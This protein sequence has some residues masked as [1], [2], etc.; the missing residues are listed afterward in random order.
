MTRWFLAV[1]LLIPLSVAGCGRAPAPAGATGK[2]AADGARVE[3]PADTIFGTGVLAHDRSVVVAFERAGT[4]RAVEVDVGDRVT[5]GQTLAVLD[6]AD[7]RTELAREQA[8]RRGEQASLGRLLSDKEQARL[9]EEI[10]RR[11]ADRSERLLKAGAIAEVE[12][13]H[14]QDAPLL[15][16]QDRRAI[17]LQ[18]GVILARLAQAQAREEQAALWK[19]KT[20]LR[21]AG[22]G[23]VV[24]RDASAG[25]Y[26]APGA[27]VLVVAPA[28]SE[29]ASLWVHESELPSLRLGAPVSLSLR[30]R[31]RTGLRGRVSRIHPEADQHNHEVRVDV[32]LE[33]PPENLVFGVRIDGKISRGEGGQ[34]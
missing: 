12:R 10:A 15:L 2:P 8:N 18:R 26:T 23:R 29:V 24:R 17:E 30:D 3:A 21:A 9:R 4:I 28:G 33:Q 25:S 1:S 31:E 13:D 20:T 5:E 7:A 14:S 6:D 32:R 27:P 34:P 22:P 19:R 16:A 11:E